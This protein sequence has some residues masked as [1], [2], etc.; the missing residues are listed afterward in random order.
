[1]ERRPTLVVFI[2]LT[3]AAI[4][5]A[6][7][8]AQSPVPKPAQSRLG[9]NLAGPTDWSTEYPFV[10]MFKLSRSWISQKKGQAWGKGPELT[11]DR[12]GWVTR[13]EPDCSAETPM[14][15]AGHAPSGRYVCLYEGQGT[16]EIRG[17]KRVVSSAPGRIV[18]DVDGLKGGLFLQLKA[19]EPGNYVK[20]IRFLMPGT[21]KTYRTEPFNPVFL[22]KWKSFNTL[23]FMDWMHTNGSKVATWADRPTPHSA[24]YTA[25]G[26]PVEVMCDLCNRLKVNAW[27][28]MPHLADDDFV[29]RFA[30]T[31]HQ[32]LDRPL[33]A[34]VEYSNEVWNGIFPQT[35]YAGEQGLRLKLGDKPWE[36]GWRYSARRSVEIFRIW[37][38]V[39][40]G[41]ERF[42]RVIA[43][44]MVGYV[45]EQKLTFE[46][47][48]KS[49][50]ALAIA[51]YIQFSIPAQGE[52]LTAGA[53]AGWSVDQVLDS[54]EEKSLAGSVRGIQEQKALAA[55]YHVKLI[56][57]EAGQHAVGVGG[58]ENVDG[59]TR[60]LHQANRHPRM[61]RIYTK[62]LD[63]WRASG[64]DL[65]AIFS[66]TGQWS[67]WG[68][69][70][71]S[72]FME[73]T[74]AEQPKLR[75]VLEWNCANPR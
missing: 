8:S 48:Y 17:V 51:P 7:A 32:R 29:R 45:S 60:L 27:F 57:Y 42:V 39:F 35:R 37:E 30:Q 26:V 36:A 28:C 65:C 31:V 14:L 63:A 2:A 73:E 13:L 71:M 41:R 56:A 53:V 4:W 18:V 1:M 59:L 58:G 10:D 44:Q 34:Y 16:I 46:D 54:M 70:G 15:T 19:T 20:N 40:G 24:T 74:P 69:W 66:S 12:D 6:G 52:G 61:G 23:R 64:G 9:I 5:L 21:E 49:C 72:E 22:E 11:L 68:S 55:R 38:E 47:A 62:Y 75:A 43:S 25:K 3:L 67:K 50:D 33:V